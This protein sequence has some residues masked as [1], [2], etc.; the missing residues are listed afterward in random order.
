MLK[1][2][3][4]EIQLFY[5]NGNSWKI[6]AKE[7][8]ISRGKLCDGVKKGFLKSRSFSEAGNGRK[9]TEETKK[10]ISNYRKKYLEENPDKVPY[11]LNHSSKE[12]YPEKYFTELFKKENIKILK[13]FRIGLYE[14]DFCI[15]DKKIDIEIDGSQH[16]LDKKIIESDKRR[17]KFLEECGWDVI[18][19]DWSK[20]QSLD[21]LSKKEFI[22]ELK[23]YI[24]EISNKK[25]TIEIIKIKKGYDL[26]ECGV[27]KSKRSLKC[28]LC[29]NKFISENP[30]IKLERNLKKLNNYD[31]CECGKE[32][33]KSSKRC[34]DCGRNSQRKSVRPPLNQLL[35]EIEELG[36]CGTGRKYGVSDSAIR[37]WIK[38]YRKS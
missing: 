8:D 33:W 3:W 9:Q 31:L 14:L 21:F 36:Y 18:R 10:K 20:Y 19:I 7:F 35:S 27:E 16:Y 37:K 28:K 17:T 38:S 32:K 1:C 24:S 11:V 15:P 30:A 6:V 4:K 34:V 23:N 12:S 13:F 26:C 25:P 29:H 2:D 22:R 5:D